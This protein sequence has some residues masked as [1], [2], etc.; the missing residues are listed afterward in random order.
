M[1]TE[2]N[3]ERSAAPIGAAASADVRA[4]TRLGHDER[5]AQILAAARRLLKHRPYQAVSNTQ[6]AIAAKV[7]RGLVNHYFGTRRELYLALVE[8]LLAAP[9]VRA[10]RYVAGASLRDR[11]AAGVS[12]WME[13]LSREPG[14]MQAATGLGGPG[15]DKELDA[16]VDAARSRAVDAVAEMVG[17]AA[18]AETRPEVRALLRAY[19]GLVEAVGREWLDGGRLS[20]EQTRVLLEEALLA[21]VDRVLP[22]VLDAAHDPQR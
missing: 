17:L 22:P 9:V 10:P 15:R 20:A 12:G 7:S 21:L 13:L 19:S 6:I 3:G 5:R 2:L 16:I 18:L 1:T 4:G 8:D 11:V 14:V